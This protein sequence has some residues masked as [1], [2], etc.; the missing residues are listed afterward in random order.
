MYVFPTGCCS[1][2]SPVGKALLAD[3]GSATGQLPR[4][5]VCYISIS[6]AYVSVFIVEIYSHAY[7]SIYTY[8]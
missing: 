3:I 2:A 1:G 8:I 5:T 7:L 6:A 4:F